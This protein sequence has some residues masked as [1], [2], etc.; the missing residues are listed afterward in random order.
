M[1]TRP[2]Y[3]YYYP[4]YY[5]VL[6]HHLRHPYQSRPRPDQFPCV[7]PQTKNT[8]PAVLSGASGY[9]AL[10]VILIQKIDSIRFTEVGREV[11]RNRNDCHVNEQQIK[12]GGTECHGRTPEQA[13]P[14]GGCLT[15]AY[16]FAALLCQLS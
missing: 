8:A 3:P 10:H 15:P 16:C 6:P 12:D 1:P 7:T 5:Y 9:I 13:E 4:Y 14:G 2:Y 11:L